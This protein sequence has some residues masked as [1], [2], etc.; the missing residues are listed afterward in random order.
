MKCE[1]RESSGGT[2][3]IMISLFLITTSN[4]DGGGK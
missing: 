4:L 3:L 2:S 1:G